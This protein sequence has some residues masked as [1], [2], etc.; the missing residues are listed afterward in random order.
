MEKLFKEILQHLSSLPPENITI[1]TENGKKQE[2]RAFT[3]DNVINTHRK[4]PIIRL[5]WFFDEQK[6]SER[7]EMESIKKALVEYIQELQDKDNVLISTYEPKE[8]VGF[9][10]I[11]PNGLQ[12]KENGMVWQVITPK[13]DTELGISNI[14]REMRDDIRWF[15]SKIITL[16]ELSQKLA[17]KLAEEKNKRNIWKTVEYIKG[18]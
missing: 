12:A 11:F 9:R 3:P 18:K 13:K 7:I 1:E 5:D 15:P 2:E 6:P 16:E 17:V 4:I 14:N 10:V 8:I